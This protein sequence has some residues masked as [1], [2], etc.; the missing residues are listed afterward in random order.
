MHKIGTTAQH[1]RTN[2]VETF[3]R[4]VLSKHNDDDDEEIHPKNKCVAWMLS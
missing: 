2:V 3:V 1:M 4:Y